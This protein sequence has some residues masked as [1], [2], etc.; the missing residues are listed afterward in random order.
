MFRS[1][2][3]HVDEPSQ[4]SEARRLARKMALE[5]GFNEIRHERVAIVVTEACTNLLK[6]AVGGEIVI[7]V[8]DALGDRSSADMEILALDRGPGMENLELCLENGY[9]SGSSLGQGLGAIVRLSDQS[10]FFVI[11]GR[12]T[13]LLARW[14]GSVKESG[15]PVIGGVNVAKQ[16]EESCGDSWGVEQTSETTT[17]MVADGLGHG[18]DASVASLNA[19]RILHE[20]T[21]L[22]PLALIELSHQALRSTRGAA[23]SVACIHHAD[24]TV[25][26]CG[27]GNVTAQIYSGARPQQHLV[28][29]NGTAG[30]QMQRIREFSYPWPDRGMLVLHSDGLST[31]AGLEGQPSLAQRD[32][33]LIAGVLYRDYSRGNDDSTVVVLKA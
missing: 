24:K 17:V 7:C 22:R 29:V 30:H 31:A 20:N 23:V 4:I 21:G 28:T 8:T 13:A 18:Y 5:I 16:G 6:H 19:V 12:G 3:V 9:T 11:Q 32:P 27:V 14:N 25:T 33:S 26:Y 2:R 1:I 15:C 10:D